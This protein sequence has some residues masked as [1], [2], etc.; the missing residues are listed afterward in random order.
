MIRAIVFDCF[1]V[2]YRDNASML[3]DLVP[4]EDLQKLKDIIRA[5]D[6]GFL[7]RADYYAAVAALGNTSV[8]VVKEIDSK[9]FSRNEE[10][11]A[12]AV[13]LK[14]AYKLGLLSNIGQ[15]V[16]DRLFTPKEQTGIFD[17][18]ILSSN[19]GVTKPSVQAFEAVVAA[20]GTTADETIMIDDVPENVD[21]ARL[22]G[23]HGLLFTSNQQLQ[24]D[25]TELLAANA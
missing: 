9:Q 18:F 15:G 12:Y 1:G 10:L 3:Y 19:I 2:L 13:S 4:P 6:Y 20:L 14:P 16:M 7:S 23:M 22:A 21:G 5:S 24:H 11:V 17:A 25:L 8:E